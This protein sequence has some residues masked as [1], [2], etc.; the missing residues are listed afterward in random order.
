[1]S[2]DAIAILAGVCFATGGA[3]GA[4]LTWLALRQP[5][6][7]AAGSPTDSA[8]VDAVATAGAPAE[9]AARAAAQEIEHA[10]DPVVDARVAELLERGRA[11]K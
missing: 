3:L 1:L 8:V 2:T 9:N 4:W 5:P 7:A 11:G 6:L 10:P